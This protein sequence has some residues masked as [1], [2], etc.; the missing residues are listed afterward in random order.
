MY[1]QGE[2]VIYP[3][4]GACVIEEVVFL[5]K[6]GT[7]TEYLVLRTTA[8]DLK[9]SLPVARAEELGLRPPV[10]GDELDDLVVLLQ[11]TD[12]RVPSNW[13]RRLKNHQEKLR[14][15]DVYQ[16]AEVVRNLALRQQTTVLSNA[17]RDMFVHARNN[18]V[19]E[20][21]PSLGMSVD[22]AS[23][24]LGRVLEGEAVGPVHDHVLPAQPA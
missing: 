18:L 19:N 14:S 24:F 4:H 1:Q 8:D 17:E 2:T 7:K 22:D 11:R 15:G 5:D 13:S 23:S 9:V 21:A 3:H 10:S 12:V 6:L 16:V 20:L